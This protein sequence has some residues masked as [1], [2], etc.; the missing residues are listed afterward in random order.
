MPWL[1][2]WGCVSTTL[3][4]SCRANVT[5]GEGRILFKFFVF[6]ALLF[7]FFLLN[8]EGWVSMILLGKSTYASDSARH[9]DLSRKWR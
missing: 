3:R 1:R 5:Y 6:L 7:G 8:L 9:D 2:A 4:K